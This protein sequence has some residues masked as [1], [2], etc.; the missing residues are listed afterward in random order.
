MKYEVSIYELGDILK[1]IEEKYKLSILVKKDLSG[2]WLTLI[3]DAKIELLPKLASGCHGK[4][5]NII[6]IRL[7]SDNIE[8]SVIKLTGANNRLFTIDVS[9]TRFKE[10]QTNSIALEKIMISN[11]ECKLRIDEDI[12]FTIKENVEVIQDLIAGLQSK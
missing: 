7:E 11:E 5:T 6:E 9:S 4:S 2:G 3:A 12:I 10:I 1:K 8:G